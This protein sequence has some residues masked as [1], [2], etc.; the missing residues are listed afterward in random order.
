MSSL[1]QHP[2]FYGETTAT[3]IMYNHHYDKMYNVI[4]YVRQKAQKLAP[5]S[6]LNACFKKHFA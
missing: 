2:T 4:L 6:H 5:Q 3:S 1:Q